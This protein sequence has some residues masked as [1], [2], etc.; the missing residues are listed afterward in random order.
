MSVKSKKVFPVSGLFIQILQDTKSPCDSEETQGRLCSGTCDW[1]R[2]RK[3]IT[4]PP[5][6]SCEVII[7][8]VSANLDFQFCAYRNKMKLVL[9]FFSYSL[10]P[11]PFLIYSDKH[12]KIRLFIIPLMTTYKKTWCLTSAY[13]TS[14]PTTAIL[15]NRQSKHQ[16]RVYRC[17]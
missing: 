15:E 2:C 6:Y 14:W 17:P 4:N 7:F 3:S 12:L 16:R 11:N 13:S 8:S 5:R 9:L 1:K 10:L